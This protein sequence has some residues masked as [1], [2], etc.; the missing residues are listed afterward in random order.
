MPNIPKDII[1]ETWIDAGVG[2]GLLGLAAIGFAVTTFWQQAF[3][4]P[5]PEDFPFRTALLNLSSGV[6]LLSGAGLWFARNRRAAALT[7]AVLFV[8][9]TTA[10]L[11]RVIAYAHI[12]GAWLGFFE[13]LVIA[14]GAFVLWIR[15]R[16]PSSIGRAQDYAVRLIY[17]TASLI[18]GL[19][20]MFSLKETVDL[21]P[22]WMPGSPVF[23]A[24]STGVAHILV[25]AALVFDRFAV[26]ATRLAAIMYL[27]FTMVVWVPQTI[28][29]PQTGYVWSCTFLSLLMMG[30]VWLLSDYLRGRV[31]SE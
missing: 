29:Q 5:V 21:I 16:Y 27:V 26:L 11:P 18:F 2:P 4:Q 14:V 9:L 20:H 6:M 15:L 25:T 12:V 8:I 1:P 30:A 7:L 10:F 13:H 17:A 22:G 28:L 19:S 3:W 23:W 31:L 24:I